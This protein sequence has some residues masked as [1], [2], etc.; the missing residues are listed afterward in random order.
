MDI[1][2]DLMNDC[3]KQIKKFKSRVLDYNYDK[4]KNLDFIEFGI[5]FFVHVVNDSNRM[6]KLKKYLLSIN[7]SEKEINKIFYFFL[8]SDYKY[9]KGIF[10][11]YE[12]FELDLD[13]D[14]IKKTTTTFTIL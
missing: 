12:S 3:K 1:N 8:K 7:K 13:P 5:L 6:K 9:E 4:F 11:F 2:F 14:I 10:S